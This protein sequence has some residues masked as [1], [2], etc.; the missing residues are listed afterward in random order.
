MEGQVLRKPH[1]HRKAHF[2]GEPG[3]VAASRAASSQG[4]LVD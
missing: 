1:L 3:E 4:G 2:P